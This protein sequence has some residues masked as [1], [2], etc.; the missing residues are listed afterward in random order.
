M[1]VRV[2]LQRGVYT[3]HDTLSKNEKKTFKKSKCTFHWKN[4]A[5]HQVNNKMKTRSSNLRIYR[6]FKA[7]CWHAWAPGIGIDV[8]ACVVTFDSRVRVSLYAC[9]WFHAP[10]VCV[11][12][13]FTADSITDRCDDALRKPHNLI[14]INL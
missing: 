10:S 12:T 2:R 9:T 8:H 13:H 4:V 7:S 6:V 11:P 14:L 1:T 3:A 5:M